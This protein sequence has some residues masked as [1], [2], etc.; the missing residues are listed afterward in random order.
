MSA[1]SNFALDIVYTPYF[2]IEVL[3]D[4]VTAKQPNDP[5]VQG[6]LYSST[7][8]SLLAITSSRN[9]FCLSAAETAFFT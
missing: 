8:Q 3:S 7:I 9:P 1:R 5:G 2:G 6:V 4:L